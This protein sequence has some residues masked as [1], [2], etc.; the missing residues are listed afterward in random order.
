LLIG[1]LSDTHGRLDSAI[2]DVFAGVEHII[3]AG[4]V[5]DRDILETLAV[6]AP[7]TAVR[8]NCDEDG[9]DDLPEAVTAAFGD[10][11]LHVRHDLAMVELLDAPV[12]AAMQ[13]E[14]RGVIIFGH[15]HVPVTGRHDGVF[16]LNPGSASLTHYDVP[17]SVA[18]LPVS[19]PRSDLRDNPPSTGVP[20]AALGRGPANG[21]QDCEN[22]W[23]LSCSPTGCL[24]Q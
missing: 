22:V 10:L 12:L 8:G 3:H 24:S 5:G 17:R 16:Y 4:D 9:W 18:L 23:E 2:V 6:L 20:A 7:V 11:T 15:S 21:A 14:A 13:R 19:V 1:V